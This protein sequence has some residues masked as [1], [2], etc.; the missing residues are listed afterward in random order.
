MSLQEKLDKHRVEFQK[1]APADAQEIMQRATAE[2]KS[3][4]ILDG[5]IKKGDKAPSFSLPDENGQMIESDAFLQKGPLVISFYR[6][7]W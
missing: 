5:V 6:G 2:L 7:V 3:S 1:K 4:G